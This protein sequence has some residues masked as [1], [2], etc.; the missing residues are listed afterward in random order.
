M[1]RFCDLLEKLLLIVTSLSLFFMVAVS[2]M[3]I[4]RRTAIGSSFTWA[5]E[6]SLL[7]FGVLVFCAGP[8]VFRR[9]RDAVVNY[10]RDKLFVGRSVLLLDIVIDIMMLCFLVVLFIFSIKLQFLQAKASAYYLPITRNWFS[11]PVVVFALSTTIFTF[12][13]FLSDIRTIRSGKE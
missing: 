4:I 6:F 11:F 9:K 3:E 2:T 12:E 8:V 13:N 7:L 1:K 5:Q 10:F